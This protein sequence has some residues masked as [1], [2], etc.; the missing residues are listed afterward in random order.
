MVLIITQEIRQRQSFSRRDIAQRFFVLARLFFFLFL[1]AF[2]CCFC[3]SLVPI[4]VFVLVIELK[5]L[6]ASAIQ[7]LALDGGED[8][9]E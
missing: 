8:E 3:F 4:L 6:H 9:V 2:L 7:A 5:D 1:F